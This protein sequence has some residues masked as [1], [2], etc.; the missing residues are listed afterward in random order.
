MLSLP[1]TC[2]TERAVLQHFGGIDDA[3]GGAGDCRGTLPG[4]VAEPLDMRVELLERERVDRIA[5][6]GVANPLGGLI[7]S[8]SAIPR[9]AFRFPICA[10]LTLREC[11]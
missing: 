8:R 9:I 4:K 11:F 2:V 6:D 5:G 10:S 7:V 3:E 1:Q